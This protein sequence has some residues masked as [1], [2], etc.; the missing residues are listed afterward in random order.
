MKSDRRTAIVALLMGA[1]AGLAAVAAR[2]GFTGAGRVVARLGKPLQPQAETK[3]YG[4][5]E[6][7]LS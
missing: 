5:K 4:Y 2:R 6:I 7:D 1:L 3:T